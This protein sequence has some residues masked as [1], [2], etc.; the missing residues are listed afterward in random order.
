MSGYKDRVTKG[1][2]GAGESADGEYL[3]WAESD[4]NT[5]IAAV[6]PSDSTDANAQLIAETGTVFH[7]T[8]LTPR[9]LAEQRAELLAALKS[10][11]AVCAGESLSKRALVNALGYAR[12]ALAKLEG[13]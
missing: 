6:F 9:E 7:E 12:D 11:A 13:G 10:C 1:P 3:L 4:P 5:A 8:G 2:W